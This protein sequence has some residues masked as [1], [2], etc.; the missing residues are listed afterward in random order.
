MDTEANKEIKQFWDGI[1]AP[2][3][4]FAQLGTAQTGV[5]LYNMIGTITGEKILEV[6]CGS[7]LPSKMLYSALMPAGATLFACDISPKMVDIF[8]QTVKTSD[9]H[10]NPEHSMKRID[11]GVELIKV[12]EEIKSMEGSQKIVVFTANNESLPLDDNKFDRYV[13][14][15]SLHCVDNHINQLKEAYRVMTVGGK[16]GFSVWGRKEN[17]SFNTVLPAVLK[18]LGIEIPEPSRPYYYLSDR[19]SIEKDLREVGFK[20][21]KTFF[22]PS[23]LETGSYKDL[24]NYLVDGPTFPG[25]IKGHEDKIAEIEAL[26]EV[27]YE[28]KFGKETGALLEFEVLVILCEK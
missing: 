18:S 5:T 13:S 17:S 4:S 28:R 3:S 12:D 23:N 16:A 14:N 6:G 11:E 25:L 20:G 1:S 7:G 9:W 24:W 19:E 8:E 10:L 15:L 21:V 2:Y 22:T 26:F 27:E